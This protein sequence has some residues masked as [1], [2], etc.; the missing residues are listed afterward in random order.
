M[1]AVF[2]AARMASTAPA[3]SGATERGGTAD[4]GDARRTSTCSRRNRRALV[5]EVSPSGTPTTIARIQ[6]EYAVV[7]RT[8]WQPATLMAPPVQRGGRVVGVAFEGSVAARNVT[9]ALR[10]RCNRVSVHAAS[11]P[12]SSGRKRN[13]PAGKQVPRRPAPPPALRRARPGGCSSAGSSPSAETSRWIAECDH[14]DRVEGRPAFAGD[15]RRAG[16]R[17]AG[18]PAFQ[19]R[20]FDALPRLA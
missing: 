5:V 15:A 11:Q 12:P 4:V 20:G 2:G 3:A 8:T 6:S 17:K 7:R 19:P 9:S 14:G 16:G 13:P 1:Q 10:A 18:L